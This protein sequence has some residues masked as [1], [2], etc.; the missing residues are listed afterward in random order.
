MITPLFIHLHTPNK[1]CVTDS[2]SVLSHQ[3]PPGLTTRSHVVTHPAGS[4]IRPATISA[5]SDG[6]RL[7][8]LVQVLLARLTMAALH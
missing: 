6:I 1:V 4:F 7:G 5:D 3:I 2:S 8:L